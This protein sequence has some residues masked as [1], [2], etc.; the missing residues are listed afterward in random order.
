MV[1]ALR[2]AGHEVYDFKHP[3]VDDEGFHWSEIDPDWETWTI[4]EYRMN[5]NHPVARSGFSNDFDAMRWAD[6]FVLVMPSGRSA[7]IEAG[8]AIGSRKPTCILIEERCEP[9]LMYKL[10]DAIALDVFEVIEWLKGICG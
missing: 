8:W 10:A 5:L 9:E 3:A 4:P 2:Q 7:H 6:A 1:N